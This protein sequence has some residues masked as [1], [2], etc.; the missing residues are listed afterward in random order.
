LQE[1]RNVNSLARTQGEAPS[2]A[3]IR[4]GPGPGLV[5]YVLLLGA[6]GLAFFGREFPGRLPWL[7]ERLTPF[8]FG[9]FVALF[10]TYRFA[11]VRIHK[12]PSFKAFYQVGLALVVFLL[13]LPS[14]RAS[15]GPVPR[16]GLSDYLA[17]NNA[18][19]RAL[20]AEVVRHRPDATRYAAALVTGLEDEDPEVRLQSYR[21]LVAIAGVDL[22]GPESPGAIKRWRERFP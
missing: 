15:Y 1:Q 19:V 21:S 16:P 12:Y 18:R 20:A 22:G 2:L 3:G 17:D 6:A 4:L 9:A 10:A 13:L 7:V 5:L 8:V 11:L 14:S